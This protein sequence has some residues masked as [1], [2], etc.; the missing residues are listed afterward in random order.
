MALKVLK[1]PF[2]P[3]SSPNKKVKATTFD[4]ILF[5]TYEYS[6]NMYYTVKFVL[7]LYIVLSFKSILKFSMV[8]CS[9]DLLILTQFG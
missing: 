9:K 2:R 4:Q 8:C 7:F 5:R 1:G 6:R 3:P